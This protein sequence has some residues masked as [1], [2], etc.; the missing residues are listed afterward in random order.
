MTAA[1]APRST[2][3]L[4]AGAGL[5]AVLVLLAI[6]F[7]P[8]L[9][10]EFLN[11]DLALLSRAAASADAA[12]VAQQPGAASPLERVALA[13]TQ[14][15]AGPR[16]IAFHAVSI[17][18]HLC[19]TSA[20]FL[21]ARRLTQRVDLALV[22]AAIFGLHPVHGESVA[23]I[24]AL[25]TSLAAL[26]V[27]LALYAHT[28][29][30][31]EPF[32]WR[33]HGLSAALFVSG[34]L[35]DETA[36]AFIPMALVIDLLAKRPG[37][38]RLRWSPYAIYVACAIAWLVLRPHAP[39]VTPLGVGLGRLLALR[40]ELFGQALEQL[41]WPFGA[42]ITY[43]FRPTIDW[44]S[45]T[46]VLGT[47][48]IAAWIGVSAWSYRTRRIHVLAVALFV[49][50][51]LLSPLLMLPSAD[52][53]PVT[54]EHLY[55]SAAGFALVVAHVATSKAGVV[56]ASLISIALGIQTHARTQ[57]WKSDLTMLGAAVAGHPE[58]PTLQWHL[59]RAQLQ[60]Y[61]EHED[62]DQL[63]AASR[64]FESALDLLARAQS[65][66]RSIFA[67][68]GDFLQSNLGLG[69][70]ILFRS[71][72]DPYGIDDT[73]LRVFEMVAT[74]YPDSAEA[75]MA[76]G[77][78][79]LALG[80]FD[81]SERGFDKAL[82]LRPGF[83][84]ALHNLG[85]LRV[86][87]RD[88]PRAIEA[89]EQALRSRPDHLDDLVSLA[90]ALAESGQE[91]RALQTA[92]RAALLAPNSPLPLVVRGTLDARRGAFDSALSWA[93]RALALAPDDG[94]ALLLRGKILLAR[95]EL[96]GARTAFKRAA[97]RLPQ[98]F[99]AHYNLAALYLKENERVAAMPHLV[100]A[101]ALRPPDVASDELR[102]SLQDVGI[103]AP[104][105]YWR[106]ASIDAER[107]QLANAEDWL[108]RA[109]EID[110]EHGP[111]HMLLGLV[112]KKR[113]DI[114]GAIAA[115]EHACKAMPS[116][117]PA[118]YTLGTTLV[119][120]GRAKDGLA[121]LERALEIVTKSEGQNS[122]SAA[123]LEGLRQKIDDI[124][125]KSH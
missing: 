95:G 82:S 124:K 34:L 92:D 32:D 25:H 40:V 49:P 22:A 114:D 11:E 64:S 109:L 74:R 50:A 89:F 88:W 83:P 106:L 37:T 113:G 97:D 78:A 101:Y 72:H 8:A 60:A 59:G 81:D 29:N 110:P 63:T 31:R 1:Q 16:P 80:R 62:L 117:Y 4:P 122:E 103:Q 5:L 23:R 20:L 14:Q 123:A 66:D 10:G 94:E 41:G 118:H 125:S 119:D 33:R 98:S 90:R 17:F 104:E 35:A 71:E 12:V 77:V 9:R 99:E 73:A 46:V 69:W 51:A 53:F 27:L 68:S 91:Q 100:Q 26:C 75:H 13:L 15:I 105:T 2:G 70:S 96:F 121:Y 112:R 65:G 85:Q 45:S 67:T 116:S 6:A 79:A 44:S 7:S 42:E 3:W 54:S 21:L 52:S 36:L 19:A 18:V 76:L 102:R 84:E 57:L 30:E 86:R 47:C 28:G 58:S 56:C 39:T 55:L 111:S 107:G 87:R 108:G 48:G 43:P 38:R 120:A 61:T 93:D 24:S 115:M